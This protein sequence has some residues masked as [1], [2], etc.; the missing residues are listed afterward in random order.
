MRNGAALI[1]IVAAT[2]LFAQGLVSTRLMQGASLSEVIWRMAGYFT[3][4]SNVATAILMARVAAG[5]K[6]SATTAGLIT[7][8]MVVVALGYHGLLAGI[9]QPHGLAWWADQGLHTVVPG[10]LVLWWVRFGPKAG[11]VGRDALRWIIWPVG[12]AVYAMV[13]GLVSGFYPYPFV[14]V[15]VLGPVQA[16]M[17]IAALAVGFAVLSL[18]FIGVARVIR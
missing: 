7:V 16:A 17:N 10:L 11:L 18:L 1:A 3:V 12:Y 4:L 8:V 14:D 5:G 9:W 2:A 6:L 13:R 15:Q